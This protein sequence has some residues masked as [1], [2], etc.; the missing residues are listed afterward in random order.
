MT[1]G[2]TIELHYLLE[3]PEDAP[4]VVLANS[5]GTTL[6]VWDDQAPALQARLLRYD[7]RGHGGS[8][9]PPGPY[10]IEDLGR[11]LLALLDRL[12]L[13]RISFCGISIGGTATKRGSSTI[14]TAVRARSRR[15]PDG[16]ARMARDDGLKNSRIG[17]GT[18]SPRYSKIQQGS[19]RDSRR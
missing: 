12:G 11:D 15:R 18:L 13:E 6:R 19:K 4:V 14:T 5:L 8:P 3:G 2:S 10:K 9:V 17:C 7:H 16:S 1:A